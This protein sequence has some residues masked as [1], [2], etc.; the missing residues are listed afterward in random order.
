[1][2][3]FNTPTCFAAMS[4][5]IGADNLSREFAALPQALDSIRLSRGDNAVILARLVRGVSSE[6]WREVCDA[7]PLEKWHA[8]PAPAM[9][10][11][12]EEL[13]DLEGIASQGLAVSPFREVEGALTRSTFINLLRRE[14][15]RISR[16]GGSLSLIGASLVDRRSV[17][18]ALGEQTTLRLEALLGNTLLSRLDCCDALGLTRRGVFVCSLPGL[19][20]LAARRFAETAQAAFQDIARPYFPVGGLGAGKSP[21]CA[22]GIVNILQGEACSPDDL[23]KRARATLDI[24]M[25]KQSGY[26]HQEAAM[27][28]FEG[29]TLVHSSEKRFLFFGGD[30]K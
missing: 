25:R 30:P 20:Q 21:T 24:A 5:R 1:M 4:N 10:E 27:A 9:A 29:T 19:G 17:A 22:M 28:P 7:W 3:N 6:S 11:N 23:L 12:D 2:T 13:E 8:L 15:M 26:I 16:N 14:L 18:V